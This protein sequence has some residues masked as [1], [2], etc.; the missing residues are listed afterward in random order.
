MTA[1]PTHHA[2]VG[3]KPASASC[4]PPCFSFLKDDSSLRELVKKLYPLSHSYPVFTMRTAFQDS[5]MAENEMFL[6][7]RVFQLIAEKRS[8]E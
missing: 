2:L 7:L 1:F 8:R 3:P 4:S 5:Q 6:L